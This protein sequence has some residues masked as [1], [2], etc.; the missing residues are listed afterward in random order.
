MHAASTLYVVAT[1]F[2]DAA[3]GRGLDGCLTQFP[4]ADCCLLWFLAAS[5]FATNDPFAHLRSKA[6]VDPAEGGCA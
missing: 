1:P 4:A 3:F 5:M 2:A 6:P